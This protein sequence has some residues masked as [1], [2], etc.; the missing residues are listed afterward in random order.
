[1]ALAKAASTSPP[2][3]SAVDPEDVLQP[4]RVLASVIRACD[5]LFGATSLVL[6]M[7]GL[8]LLTRG[9]VRLLTVVALWSLPIINVVWSV[10][11]RR[12]QRRAAEL[13][14]GVVCLP[15][16]SFLYVAEAGMLE[17]LWFPAL[18]ATVGVALSV[19]LS[20]RTSLAGCL[21]SLGYAV[22]LFGVD[23]LWFWHIDVSAIND[24]LGIALTGCVVSIVANKLG[25]TLAEARRQRDSAHEQKDRAEAVLGQLTQRSR[26]LTTAVDSLQTEMERRMRVE[27]E[28]RQAQ[29]LESVGRLAAGVAHEI[30]TPV[31]FV[32]DSLQFVREGVTDLFDVVDKLEGLR[33]ATEDDAPGAAI[34]DDPDM[35]YLIENLPK[36]IE[37]ALDGLGRVSTIVRSLKEFAHPD[38]KEMAA[39]D[40]N[41]AI[42]S[43]LTMARNEYKYVADL[44]TELGDLPRVRCHIGELNQALLNIVV[45]AAHAIADTV[46]GT[47]RRGRIRVTT[48]RDGD[49][50]VIAIADTGGGIPEHV[51]DRIFDPFF[52]TKEVG[53]GTGQGLAIARSVIVDKHRGRLDFET[54]LGEGTTFVIRLAIAGRAGTVKTPA[55]RAMP[56]VVR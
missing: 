31:Q 44:E 49:D 7:I 24:A 40:L 35:P 17:D 12:G 16:T 25:N 50:V 47:D 56:A 36:A 10:L 42:D 29:K 21:V 13:F 26:E 15:I 11:I 32:S 23:S 22:A 8:W 6:A 38:A 43:T 48:R 54:V 30:N 52:T 39:A 1:M 3:A 14:R 27:L 45:N 20:S 37:R 41:Q 51:R 46:R 5:V 55:L 33:V 34:A 9:G 4:H 53:R 2:A 28:L 18:V 19:S